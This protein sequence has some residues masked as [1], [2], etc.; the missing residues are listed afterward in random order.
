MGHEMKTKQILQ[1]FT[2]CIAI[3]LVFGNAVVGLTPVA[4]ADVPSS[5]SAPPGT[6]PLTSGWM[7]TNW[8]AGNSFFSLYTSQGKV[9]ARIWDSFN[10]GRVF[11]TA[12]D[13]ANW[14]RI[15]SADID[16]DILSI[17]LLNSNILAGTWNGFYLSTDGGATWNAVTPTGIPVDT[18]IW[19]VAMMNTALFAGTTGAIY[20]SLDNGNTWTEVSSGIPADARITSIVAGVDAIFACSAS[21]GIFKTTNGG[22]S[23]TEINS[24]LTDMHIS[25]LAVMDPKLLAVTLAGVFVSDNDGMSW[26]ASTSGLENVNCFVVANDQLFAGTD[27][28]GV[29]LSVDS[30]VTWTLFSSGMPANTRVWSLAASGDGIFAGTSSGIWVTA[31]P[32]ISIELSRFAA[33]FIAK[34]NVLVEWTTASESNSAGFFIQRSDNEFDGF[35]RLHE[36]LILA[37]GSS[38]GGATYQFIDNSINQG[39]CYYRIEEITLDGI[40]TFSNAIP[41]SIKGMVEGEISVPLTFAL[42]Q[43]YPNPF[44]QV[45]RINFSVPHR[46]QVSLNIYNLNGELVKCLVQDNLLEGNYSKTWDGTNHSGNQVTSGTYIYCLASGEQIVIRKMLLLR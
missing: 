7:Q 11:L 46:N 2:V 30:G 44:N 36:F 43:N 45:T 18:A 25:Q 40:S 28:N 26:V 6:M 37:K 14:T 35:I 31:P 15:S 33:Q 27:D 9:F 42:K 19:S 38:A 8:P 4:G 32:P 24:G 10:G 12:D 34:N 3:V 13:G 16:I 22:T 29:Y 1:F 41:T 23:W 21:S 39:N 17:V 5:A 20:K